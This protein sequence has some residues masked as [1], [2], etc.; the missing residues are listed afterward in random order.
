MMH[1]DQPDWAEIERR[2]EQLR[3]DAGLGDVGFADI[4][5]AL[6]SLVGQEVDAYAWSQQFIAK[7]PNAPSLVRGAAEQRR[8]TTLLIRA[9]RHFVSMIPHEA[10]I[11]WMVEAAR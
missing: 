1:G 9:H 2:A 3:L 5:G 7:M 11:M 6:Q 8:R 10:S 4:A